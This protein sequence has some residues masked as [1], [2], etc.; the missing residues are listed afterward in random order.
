MGLASHSCSLG[1]IATRLSAVSCMWL[2]SGWVQG[3]P[4][5]LGSASKSELSYFDCLGL[6]SV[7]VL[8]IIRIEYLKV[9]KVYCRLYNETFQKTSEQFAISLV[10]LTLVLCHPG[11]R[12]IKFNGYLA[13]VKSH[14]GNVCCFFSSLE[15]CSGTCPKVVSSVDESN[16][17]LLQE[18][19]GFWHSSPWGPS[20]QKLPRKRRRRKLKPEPVRPA[21]PVGM[22]FTPGS[23]KQPMHRWNSKAT[24]WGF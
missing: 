14:G 17:R 7:L 12:C 9:L 18:T 2:K 19:F 23:S 13:Q 11:L 8:L 4:P 21:Q 3:N 5:T 1:C 10:P 15:G 6:I 20:T 24:S 22:R 16:E